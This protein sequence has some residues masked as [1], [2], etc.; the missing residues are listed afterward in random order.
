[1]RAMASVFRA[2]AVFP[3]IVRLAIWDTENYE[4]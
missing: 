2:V 1:M 3:L 4:S